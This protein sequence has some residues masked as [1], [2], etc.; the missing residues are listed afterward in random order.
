MTSLL[1]LPQG[2]IWAFHARPGAFNRLMPPWQ[3][4]VMKSWTG[5][6]R[7]ARLEFQ[8][9]QGP[10]RITW[11]A[12]H[13]AAGYIDGEQ[14]VDVQLKGPAAAW[15]HVHRVTAKPDG[16]CELDDRVAYRLPLEPVSTMLAGGKFRADLSKMFA[17]RH[18]RTL[19]DA[20]RHAAFTGRGPTRLVI[21]GA[22]GTIG[23]ALVAYLVNAG[24]TVDRLVRRAARATGDG[25]PELPG[26]E[27]QWHPQAETPSAE[28]VA[29][30][31]GADAVIHL[32]GA[33]L[34]GRRWTDGYKAEMLA[35]RVDS[36]RLLAR[37]IKACAN[38]PESFL[39]ASGINVYQSA[40][41][42]DTS[43]RAEDGPLG[44]GFIADMAR[45]WEQAANSVA[46]V[47]RV[48]NVRLGIVLSSKGGLLRSVTAPMPPLVG[49]SRFGSG[50][51]VVPWV[52]IDD[53]L[54]A[55]EHVLHTASIAGP[56]N[57]AA[58]AVT[59]G[60]ELMAAINRARGVLLRLPAPA[61][62]VRLVAGEMGGAAFQ[63]QPV[64]P[65]K[66]LASGFVFRQSDASVAAGVELG[67]SAAIN[68][69]LRE[70]IER[71][72]EGKG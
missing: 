36:T 9:R 31:N 52:H 43:P 37:A 51:E 46:G 24:H 27:L 58:P 33:N 41:D 69:W 34:A 18:A 42:G 68:R 57:I 13:E 53:V 16:Q 32:G 14:F 49:A 39:V 62:L 48:V 47:T 19:N 20:S 60:R 28:L 67:H 38:P 7:D 22:S 3:T 56:V 44:A 63:S 8:I 26:R 30:L 65:A 71:V 4:L 2:D 72:G 61:W 54:A 15:R 23:A 29:F 12:Q 35:S 50:R 21:A 45:A 40:A 17:F 1:P 55:I 59:T 25:T 5:T 66:L 6:L 70:S 64:E 11:L 10:V